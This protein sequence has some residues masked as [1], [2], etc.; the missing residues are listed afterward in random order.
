M[1]QINKVKCIQQN[2]T[3][4]RGRANPIKVKIAKAKQSRA[5]QSK[6]KQNNTK[7]NM[8]KIRQDHPTS[9][10]RQYKVTREKYRSSKGQAKV[11]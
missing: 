10:S 4:P 8:G 2:S 7:P 3:V 6:A 1:R 5:I 11:K 9:K